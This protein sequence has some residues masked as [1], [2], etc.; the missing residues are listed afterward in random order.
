MGKV[1]RRGFATYVLAGICGVVVSYL[2]K[3]TSLA[4]NVKRT[5]VREIDKDNI[6]CSII[7]GYD[8]SIYSFKLSDV[9]I[10]GDMICIDCDT[11]DY[12]GNWQVT[13]IGCPD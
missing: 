7:K 5:G 12:I 3:P 13:Y 4:N 9:D 2:T 10:S 6:Q 8:P 1:N 11:S